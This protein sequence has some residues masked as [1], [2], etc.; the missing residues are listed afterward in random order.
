MK[1]TLL[2]YIYIHKSDLKMVLWVIVR[3]VIIFVLC[4]K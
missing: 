1:D 3:D 4:S 2:R